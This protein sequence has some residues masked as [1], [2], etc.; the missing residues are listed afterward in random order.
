MGC[1][2]VAQQGVGRGWGRGMGERTM[3]RKGDGQ[4]VGLDFGLRKPE[5]G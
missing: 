2:R 3:W 5:T 1:V 4:M